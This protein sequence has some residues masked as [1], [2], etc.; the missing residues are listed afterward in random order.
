MILAPAGRTVSERTWAFVVVALLFAFD[1]ATKAWVLYR[2]DFSE[3]AI[4]VTPFMDIVLVWNR[5]ISYGLF[6]QDGPGR[7]LLVGLTAAVTAGL[8]VWLWRTRE[9]MVRIALALVVAGAGGNLVDRIAYGA[10][11]DFVYLAYAG[12]SWYVFNVADAAIVAGVA[13]LVWDGFFGSRERDSA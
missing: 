6:Q 4:S 10:V 7:W 2:A 8:C 12:V 9:R 1:Q 5:G 11:V 13:L 3:G